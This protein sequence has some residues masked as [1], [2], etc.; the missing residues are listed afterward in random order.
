MRQMNRLVRRVLPHAQYKCGC[1][2]DIRT[3][4][5]Q[6]PAVAQETP[7]WQTQKGNSRRYMSTEEGNQDAPAPEEPTETKDTPSDGGRPN[8][9]DLASMYGYH[10]V[11]TVPKLMMTDIDYISRIRLFT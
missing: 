1:W 2:R 11:S 10:E 5:H 7:Q 9:D 6:V 3:I 8:E 4:Y